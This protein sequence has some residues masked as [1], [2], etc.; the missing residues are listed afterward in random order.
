MAP[1]IGIWGQPYL[2]LGAV[3]D[4]EA[5]ASVDAEVTLGLARAEPGQTGGS[6]KHMGVTAPWV[7][8][9]PYVDYG[10]VIE[11]FTLDQ[12]RVLVSLSDAPS[13]FDERAWRETR[14]GDETPHPLNAR[15][16]RWLTYGFGAYFPWKVCVHLLENEA[17]EDKHSGAGK[18]FTDVARERFPR[19]VEL[20][21]GLPFREIGR[22]VIFGLLPNDHAPAHRDSEPGRALSI[23]QSISLDPR[24]TKRFY[25]TDVDHEREHDVEARAYW[26]NDMDYHGVH[27]DPFFRYSIRVDG[28]FQPSFLKDLERRARA[29]SAP[30]ASADR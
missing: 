26:F 2:D 15:Q 6:L 18:D 5:I 21:R 3:L 14:F 1:L 4:V 25:L 10:H 27:A 23:A 7:D 16:I 30:R 11:R 8:E 19:T 13:A 22:V 28:V 24:G 29:A 17:W 12:W 20:V 9:D